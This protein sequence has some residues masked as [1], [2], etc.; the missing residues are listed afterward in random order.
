M[1]LQ[2]WIAQTGMMTRRQADRLI[3]E[4]R[5]KVDGKLVESGYAIESEPTTIHIDG[6]QVRFGDPIPKLYWLLNKPDKCLVSRMPQAN[7]ISIFELPALKDIKFPLQYVGRLDYRT[8]GLLL[9]TTDGELTHRL[10]HPIYKLTRVYQAV[11]NK[12]LSKAQLDNVRIHGLQ[13]DDKKVAGLRLEF[14]QGVNLGLSKGGIY[15]VSVQEGR[16]R[17]VRRVFESFGLKVVRLTRVGFGKLQLPQQL[18]SGEY[19]AL[20]SQE[21]KYLKAAVKL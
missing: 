1:K 12:K 18:R 19:R 3:S 9:L 15:N 10:T 8:D 20:T 5:V 21:I 6:K 2:K 11:T 4:G 17:I 13:I 14:I 7:K 16:N